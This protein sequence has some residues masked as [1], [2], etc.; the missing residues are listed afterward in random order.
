MRR[1][2]SAV[3][4]YFLVT[5]CKEFICQAEQNVF[6]P[7]SFSE[8][9]NGDM[10]Q[11]EGSNKVL[12]C[13][14]SSLPTP[15]YGWL[16]NDQYITNFSTTGY[17]FRFTN[18][19]RNDTGY[20]RCEARNTLG[21]LLSAP[22][23]VTVAY[24][25]DFENSSHIF[26]MSI[27]SGQA[28]VLPMPPVK[29]VPFPKS[30][31]WT[32]NQIPLSVYDPRYQISID[33]ALVLLDQTT[34][35]SNK[36]YHVTA[37]NTHSAGLE[38]LGPQ[39]HVTVTE[40]G[41]TAVPAS[42][43]VGP[44]NVTVVQD[45]GDSIKLECI[46]N[47]RPLSS[48]IVRWFRMVNGV[49]TEVV[50]S[51]D[52]LL[53]VSEK[54]RTL[55]IKNYKP[56]HSGL[57]ICEA[58]LLGDSKPV[59][60]NATLEV[61]VS[62][63]FVNSPLL[64]ETLKDYGESIT[65]SC[66]GQGIPTPTRHWYFNA[67]KL[68]SASSND[69]A[70]TI[71]SNGSLTINKILLDNDGV[72]QC[73][74]R[75]AAG[76]TYRV[77][78]LKVNSSPPELLE[79]PTNVTVIEG[80]EVLLK[81][82]TRGAPK[83]VVTWTKKTNQDER[84]A[85][86]RILD[87]GDLLI[88]SAHPSHTG[89][90][91]CNASNSHGF[92]TASAQLTVYV[93]TQIMLPPQGGK[94]IRASTVEL[95]C[96][97]SHDP[98]IAVT[99]QW[100]FKDKVNSNSVVIGSGGHM[101]IGQDGKLT[102]NGIRLDN[103]GNYTCNVVSAGG[104]DSK[105]VVLE[106]IE[107]PSPPII[108][109]VV[110]DS[111]DVRAVIVQF[112][113]DYD[114]N[115]PI[116]NFT[117]QYKEVKIDETTEYW[118]TSSPQILASARVTTVRGLRPA[119]RYQ[120]RMFAINDVG[121]G[122]PS[123]AEPR[124]PIEMPQQPP[125]APP[126]GFLGRTTGNQ[127]IT[128]FWQAPDE[129]SLN[130]ILLGYIIRFKPFGYTWEMS[131][132]LRN[133]SL[134][135]INP[136][137]PS[138]ELTGLEYFSKYDIQIAAY[139]VK[140]TG[141]Y[142]GSITYETWEGHP[143]SAP[144][145]LQAT[146]QNSTAVRL[147]WLPPD[148]QNING[149]NL[150]YKILY[151]KM[152][153]AS[154]IL[155]LT[156]PHDAL[157]PI[158]N[159]STTLAGLFK[160]TEYTIRA[161]CFT[162][163]GDG[164]ISGSVTVRTDEDVPSKVGSLT[165]TN[166]T[167]T[168]M[169]VNWTPP[170]EVNGVLV[171]YT[172]M[173]EEKGVSST[174][175]SVNRS[176]I[177]NQYKITSLRPTTKYTIYLYASTQKGA[178]PSTTADVESGVEPVLPT[179]PYNLGVSNIRER[180]VLLQF[181]PGFDGKTSISLWIVEAAQGQ[182]A[183]DFQEI[184]SIHDPDAR[185]L[186]VT[187]LKPYT[188]YQLRIIAVNIVGRSQPS[189]ASRQFQ[190]MQAAPNIPPGNLTVRTLNA[191]AL[192]IS[193]TP[194]SQSDWNGEPK[195][196][197]ISY[198]RKM[199]PTWTNVTLANGVN[200]NSFILAYLQEWM[201][202]EVKILAYNDVG[203]SSFSAV[204]LE[205]TR[206]SVPSV[207]PVNVSATA[208]TATSIE[209]TW[210]QV[211][212]LEQNGLIQGYMVEYRSIE[213][214]ISPMQK[215][216]LGNTTNSTI[217]SSLRKF[218]KYQVR[219]LA[220]TRMGPGV[221]SEPEV[222]V[223]TLEDVPGPPRIIWFPFVSFNNATIEWEEPEEPNGII[224]AYLVSWRVSG[225]SDPLKNVTVGASERKLTA[226]N[227]Q[228]QAY[229]EFYVTGQTVKGWGER[230][231]VE[232]FT[233]SNRSPPQSPSKPDIQ[234]SS[235]LA[236]SVTISWTPGHAN[237]Y[238]P[239]RN[240][241]VLYRS[242]PSGIWTSVPGT[243]LHTKTTY[244]VKGLNPNTN[245]VF[246]VAATNDVGRSPFSQQSDEVKTLEDAPEGAPRYVKV[247]RLNTTSV[248][249]SWE[250]PLPSTWNGQL[251]GYYL[252][253]RQVENTNY[254][255]VHIP[256]AQTSRELVGLEKFVNYEFQVQVYNGI[257]RGP[258]ST[259]VV[260]YVGEAAPSAPPVNVI[261]MATNSTDMS[262]TWQPP[263]KETQNG[264][265]SGYQI[266]YWFKDSPPESAKVKVVQATKLS[267]SLEGLAIYTDYAIT[268]RALNL[269][270]EG[271]PSTPVYAKTK[272]GLPDRPA[273]LEFWNVTFTSLDVQWS[274]PATPNGKILN[275]E[276]AYIEENP[277]SGSKQVKFNV[278]GDVTSLSITDLLDKVQYTFSIVAR[279]IVGPGQSFVKS[280]KIG[281]QEGSPDRPMSLTHNIVGS[282]LTLE[283]VDGLPGY[284]PIYGHLIQVNSTESREWQ[285]VS[286]VGS[287]PKAK[288]NL[289][290]FTPDREYQVR[291]VAL[292]SKGMSPPSEAAVT[293]RTP[294]PQK[295]VVASAKAFHDQWWFLVIVAMAGLIIIL[296]IIALLCL[297]SRRNKARKSSMQKTFTGATSTSN[298]A[299]AASEPEEGGFNN[300]EMNR[301]STASRRQKYAG[302]RP[303][304]A[305]NTI[306]SRAPPRPS[307]ASVSYDSDNDTASAVKPPLPDDDDD[308]DSS[309]SEK[310]SNLGDSATEASD[311][312]SDDDSDSLD[313]LPLP[314]PPA[315]PPP[316]PFSS[317]SNINYTGHLGHHSS[318][319]G[320]HSGNPRGQPGLTGHRPNLSLTPYGA[321]GGAVGG[322]NNHNQNRWPN[323]NENSS[324]NAYQYTDS[325][326]ESSHYAYSLNGGQIMLNNTAGS[327]APLPG[328]SSFV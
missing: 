88:G 27:S 145:Q 256:L 40:S 203:D 251:L 74:L 314:P 226:E 292:N 162:G 221:L 23:V 85:D 257:S 110:L 41:L 147:T 207:G 218:V 318:N 313:N 169:T 274:P 64:Q 237:G 303:N 266:A 241:T 166:I 245:Y 217:I 94:F 301:Q 220:F 141:V 54:N 68:D 117:I 63:S 38:M 271:P 186:Q 102:I 219:V 258:S 174:R 157:N 242:M 73:F 61:H 31:S 200:M 2:R 164:V 321:T 16:K 21:A 119:R 181:W 80:N 327:R 121:E 224:L 194:L 264:D 298:L 86:G 20:Y 48:L 131:S 159:Q 193:W 286:Q 161:L 116:R 182:D 7:T 138:F 60:A 279:T 151:N 270:G 288:L 12:T 36:I 206:E 243:I 265:L 231:M 190:T 195:G 18:T 105:T 107:L 127:S 267:H 47:A 130:G 178:G 62:P 3:V 236:R 208:L 51:I 177:E 322:V 228:T 76:E 238:G 67:K 196:Y 320:N 179:A 176:A 82:R 191:T 278:S 312:A 81:C 246:Q 261:A 19:K 26:N 199:V 4:I 153:D 17:Q 213:A 225:S 32:R 168:S 115:T 5:F 136:G 272:E 34:T 316:P 146:T 163:G 97:V 165:V 230:A 188:Y 302:I 232:V 254:Q 275:Y 209:V 53:P 89:L 287:E 210:G 78:R 307:P 33:G 211:P 133:V 123:S 202:Y 122:V 180:S 212:E 65:L 305:V 30:I 142:S 124:I 227:L 98:G 69:S 1:S 284:S 308:D 50:D 99:W 70:Y 185:S 10:Y 244:N 233:M 148:R 291:V 269:A 310:P 285:T 214:N 289:L 103:V 223:Q 132:Q 319:L 326:A 46:C 311:E 239:I 55:T 171:G 247:D 8:V 129:E 300:F 325:E 250:Q 317:V 6:P 328:F 49:K 170:Q 66:S 187:N 259:P 45:V 154:S 290:Q 57:Y 235:V 14:T 253:Y 273:R 75:N 299:P 58:M 125:S 72:Y 205:R 183:T 280:I 262:I 222:A 296:V 184:F 91:S 22:A 59:T 234:A 118:Q 156:V 13:K 149:R 9:P 294:A 95:L 281:P 90:Y 114:G 189:N 112:K 104:N 135:Q 100:V 134:S 263:P 84:P 120:F 255:E 52:F 216:V 79:P 139:N 77:V 108:D 324:F 93:K 137:N 304:G 28:I 42:I 323:Q 37:T 173:Y 44:K 260:V 56:S 11:A 240:F 96:G 277:F 197:K 111:E 150:G 35:D 297:I 109:S 87:N 229:Y 198:R 192:R 126:K 143:T 283:W 128:L 83:P 282:E 158:G 140:G 268:V 39:Y 201:E 155:S 175:I 215:E 315:S 167:D 29:S 309:C 144:R 204:V 252:L 15:E 101:T 248:R 152:G 306:Y 295:P 249:V 71:H 24:M 106:V 43:V 160:Y 92:I 276:I 25:D 113:P 293:F 172:L